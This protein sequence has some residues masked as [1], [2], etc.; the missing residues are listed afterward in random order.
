[1]LLKRA[2]KIFPTKMV[3]SMLEK[4][5]LILLSSVA[6]DTLFKPEM[7]VGDTVKKLGSLVSLG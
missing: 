3:R 6:M 1:M 5:A 7:I 4:N 2:Q